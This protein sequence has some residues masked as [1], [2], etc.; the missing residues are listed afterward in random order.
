MK[1]LIPAGALAA[2][3]AALPAQAHTGGAAPHLNPHGFETV[4]AAMA[5]CALAAVMAFRRKGA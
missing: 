1:Y 3:V 5:L 2:L 4:L